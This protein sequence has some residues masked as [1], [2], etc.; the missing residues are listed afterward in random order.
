MLKSLRIK[1]FK[2]WKDTGEIRLAPLTVIFGAN[3]AGKSS[4]GHLLLALKQTVL[5]ADRKRPLHLGD[6]Y[7]S[8]IDLGTFADCLYGHDLK[9]ALS[10]NLEWELPESLAVANP[11]STK[12]FV[13]NAMRLEVEL[14]A[15]KRQQPKVQRLAYSLLQDKPVLNIQYLH[16]GDAEP[17]LE[18]SEYKL[19]RNVG[20]QWPLDNPDKF[21]RISDQSRAR[22]QNA[23]FLTDFALQ[24]EAA[25]GSISY[26]GPL[27]VYPDRLY[28]WSGETPE[29]V[30]FSGENAIAAILAASEMG[31]ELNFGPKQKKLPFAVF[32][33]LWL[34][35]LGVIHHFDIKPVAENRKVYEVIVKTH[36]WS[37]PVKLT[38]VG[39]GV[40]QM[41][42]ALVQAYY[43][44]PHS[45][46]WMEQ[47]EIH[48]HPQVQAEM[49]DAFLFA[50]KAKEK[51]KD[52]HVQLIIESH[53]EH[54]LNRIQRRVAEGEYTPEHVAVYFCR[55]TDKGAELEPL[56]L[57]RK[58]A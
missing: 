32:I 23:E 5:S 56:R 50:T 39:F 37:S 48:L 42:P 33:A 13:G 1:N 36:A 58:L 51:G 45:T 8:F 53:S 6:E 29:S 17:S 27:R 41:L 11:T 21:Y 2:A 46:V 57:N 44:P 26:L 12:K 22:Y 7:S 14:M 47:P 55:R 9:Q 52:R 4:L 16:M 20:R 38:D 35:K 3:S 30:G 25:L 19:K 10:F 49:A 18:S 43:C 24:T 31:R 54:F 15:D 28:T 40:S 34:R